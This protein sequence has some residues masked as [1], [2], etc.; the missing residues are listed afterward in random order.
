[1]LVATGDLAVHVLPGE[2]AGTP[3]RIQGLVDVQRGVRLGGLDERPHIPKG[4]LP[5]D[6]RVD[7]VQIGVSARRAEETDEQF[8]GRGLAGAVGPEIAD[9]SGTFVAE[10]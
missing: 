1:K 7:S 5:V 10:R 6:H 9:R 8:E 2:T 3:D 4:S